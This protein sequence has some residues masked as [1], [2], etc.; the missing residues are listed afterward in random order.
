MIRK[1]KD[2]KIVLLANGSLGLDIAR[3]LVEEN[4]NIVALI[5]HRNYNPQCI[6]EIRDVCKSVKNVYFADQLDK[7][8]IIVEI[9]S[10]K[11]DI[12][13]S[14]WFGHILK[15]N[16][17]KIFPRG[18]INF[19]NSYLPYGRGMFPAVWAFNEPFPYGITLHYVDA[20]IDSGPIIAQKKLKINILDTGG[21]LY[22]RSLKELFDL[23]KKDWFKIRS[24][25]IE[26]FKQNEDLATYHSA[27]RINELDEIDLN[28]K[29]S[30]REFINLLRSRNFG[31]K[32][33][34]YFFENGKKIYIKLSLSE[35]S[36]M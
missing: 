11:A 5:L 17:I 28:K 32:T 1:K 16:F 6:E 36:G 34:A 19:H 23:F 26:S 13:I 7:E 18:V 27:S 22:K 4:E 9:S 24:G 2:L 33:Y 20:G 30:A 10:L 8:G 14:A 12:A 31:D 29:M 25:L 3:Y 21:T 15:E 35:D